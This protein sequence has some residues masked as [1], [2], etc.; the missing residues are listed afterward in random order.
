LTTLIAL[1][2]ITG[3]PLIAHAQGRVG[4]IGINA[5]IAGTGEGKKAIADL[6]KKYQPRQQ[7][8]GR[9]QQEIQS[10]QDK[11]SKQPSSLS[12]EEQRQLT[13]DLEDKQK[14]LKR[15]GDDA[16]TDFATDR[17]EAVR[18]IG[19]KMVRIISDYAQQNGFTLVFDG[20]QVPVYYAAKG[21]DITPEIVKRYDAANPVS[22]AGMSSKP[23]TSAS[24]PASATK[25]K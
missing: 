6:Q 10:I 15:S 2:A 1:L 16:Q 23:A 18:R 5:A 7:E 17:D 3:V 8:L 21:V 14:V 13:R 22:D 4:L 20:A 11:L 19:Q 9:L 25:P 24:S 12:E